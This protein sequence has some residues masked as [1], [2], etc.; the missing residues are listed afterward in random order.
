MGTK[1]VFLIVLPL[2]CGLFS[3][4]RAGV[5]ERLDGI[6][7]VVGEEIILQS[8]LNAYTAMRLGG[9]NSKADT[10]S[11]PTYRK[12]FLNEIIDGKVLLVHAQNDTTISVT[13]DEVD[14]ALDS[15]V[16]SILEQ[17]HI[18]ID[19][20]DALLRREQGMTLAKFKSEA[21]SAIR[22]QLLKQKV[23]RT[24]LSAVKVS[25]RDVEDFYKRYRDSLP[26]AG[27]SVLLSKLSLEVAPPA[28][29]RQA[30]YEKILSVKQK[31]SNG[32]DFA[33][34]AKRYSEGSE[35][36]SGGDL[37]FIS[38]GTLTE[39][40]FEE[41]AF[42]TPVGRSSDPFET[43]LGFHIINVLAKQ[44]QQV[45]IR[46][47]FVK[48]APPAEAVK[49]LSER[50]DSI[51]VASTTAAAFIT[52]VRAHSTDKLSKARD[53]SIGWKSLLDCSGP[54]RAAIDSLKTGAITTVLNDEKEL[55][56]YRVDDRR[57]E[58]T[59]TLEDDWPLLAEKAKDIMAQKKLV[60]LVSRWRRQVYINIR[61]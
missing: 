28:S 60:E 56:I 17:N 47:I 27:E 20:L 2:L 26:K 44:S 35:G 16:G 46:Q 8:E 37:G 42:S 22:E 45:H 39:I 53:G 38:K 3:Q 54:L 50:L 40:A 61:I 11:L 5:T 4:T 25:R 19:S 13:G 36:A 51:R 41:K 21:R 18:S 6:V 43:R 1:C 33:D 32:A 7:A 10:A 57:T 29:V 55:C 9:M 12:Q 58:R 49:K 34:L 23:Q 48:V 24:Y 31:L 30:A 59:L 15:H 14:R 52:A